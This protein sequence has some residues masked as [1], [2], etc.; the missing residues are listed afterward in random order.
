MSGALPIAIGYLL[1]RLM[2]PYVGTS[3]G[4]PY[5]VP[6]LVIDWAALGVAVVA[7]VVAAAISLAAAM[8]FLMR[9]SVTGVLRGEA[10]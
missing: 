6:V 4:V 1:L 8:R 5:P 7:I 2:M 10:E 3:L 9:S